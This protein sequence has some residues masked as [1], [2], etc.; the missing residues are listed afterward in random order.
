MTRIE[1]YEQALE[2]LGEFAGEGNDN[3]RV[4]EAMGIATLRMPLLPTELPPER[5]EMVLM[6]GR[7]SHLMATRN[8]A[9][10]DKAFQALVTRYT[11]VPNV[12]YAYGVFLL[13]EQADKAIEEFKKELELQPEHPWSLMQIAFEYVNRGD[14]K[15]ALPWA[16]R[17]VAAAPNAFAARKVLGQ[18][19][20]ETGDVEGSIK[21]TADW[22]QARP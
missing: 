14:A 16:E 9:A 15:T 22:H 11:E 10:A 1:Q 2:T 13:Q 5:R 19:L 21:R 6:A 4:V 8:T 18:A 12:H 3:P 17:A 20:L 7:A